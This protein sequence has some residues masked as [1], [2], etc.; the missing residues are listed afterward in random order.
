MA[1]FRYPRNTKLDYIKRI[2]G[3]PGDRVAF[4]GKRVFINGKAPEYTD[5]GDYAGQGDEQGARYR[6]LKENFFGVEHSILI[7]P[8]KGNVEGEVVV[9]DGHYFVV[10]DNR[11]QQQRQS[12]LGLRSGGKSGRTCNGDLDELELRRGSCQIS[13]VSEPSSNSVD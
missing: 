8:D 11:G 13:D 1:V 5:L 6:E 12:L 9:P 3:M 10:G 4:Q 7:N 2:V